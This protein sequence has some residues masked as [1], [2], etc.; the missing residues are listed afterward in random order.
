MTT[1][2]LNGSYQAL[3]GEFYSRHPEFWNSL[4]GTEF[5]LYGHQPVSGATIGTIRA[6]AEG[7]GMIYEKVGRLL[8]NAG[9]D[10]LLQLGI[11]SNALNLSKMTI[12][13][14]WD[15][16][17]GRFDFAVNNGQVKMLEFNSDTPTFIVET[18]KMNRLICDEFGVRNPNKHGDLILSTGLYE[19]IIAGMASLDKPK[20]ETMHVAFVAYGD[21]FE[22]SETAKY[23]MDLARLSEGVKKS[24]VPIQDLRIFDDGVYDAH[25]NKIDVMY[26]LY[27]IEY[28]CEDVAS[29]DGGVHIGELFFDLVIRRK[30]AIINPPSA[31]LIQGKAVQAAIWGLYEANTYFDDNDRKII[32]EYML[33]TYLDNVFT[34]DVYVEKAVYGREGNTVKIIDPK[35]NRVI[36]NSGEDY[37][38]QLKVYQ[39]YMELPVFSVETEA[40]Y[41]N[42]STIMSCFLIGGKAGAVGLRG[43]GLITNNI[44]YYI[45]ISEA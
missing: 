27:P 3:R 20:S 30:L 15:T 18:H 5:A 29:E 26:R 36:D 21:H 32:E 16:V 6:A 39:K 9:D 45:P 17:I 37:G 22:D 40:G 23:L 28:L 41:Q 2:N 42:L 38:Y 19:A 10:S 34:K 13:G 33:P 31:F 44:S 12:P 43:G 25:G 7:L 4:D 24:F 1:A 11:P 8:R 14:M 35:D